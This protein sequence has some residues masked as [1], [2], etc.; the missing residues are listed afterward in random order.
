MDV[1]K[2]LRYS[3]EH[4]WVKVEGNEVRVGITDFAQSSLGD[5]V[6]VELPKVGQKLSAAQPFGSV[7]AVKAVSDLFSPVTGEVL[8]INSTVGDDP[9]LVNSSPYGDGWMIRA[10]LNDPSE[11]EQLLDAAGYEKLV[12]EL[13]EG[14]G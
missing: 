11:L 8:E 10:T 7:E 6:F 13:E 5:I 12:A 2:D 9:T 4:E 3:K 1:P 14:N